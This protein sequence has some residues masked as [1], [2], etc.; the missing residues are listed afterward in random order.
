MQNRVPGGPK[1]PLLIL[2]RYIREHG[3]TSTRGD[4]VVWRT[5]SDVFYGHNIGVRT[6]H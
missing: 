2:C 1:A 6:V 4:G 5:V 3:G